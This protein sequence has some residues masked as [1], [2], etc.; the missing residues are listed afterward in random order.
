[1]LGIELNG[2]AEFR[3]GFV[4]LPLPL[5]DQPKIVVRL[6][7]GRVEFHSSAKMYERLSKVL[8]L[9]LQQPQIIMGVRPVGAV[10]QD[11][12]ELRNRFTEPALSS[13]CDGQILSRFKETWKRTERASE[14][15]LR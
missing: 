6:R 10:R 3:D 15:A 8:C 5:K 9:K 11:S 12:R 7:I 4:N 13:Q 14:L 1:M 2:H